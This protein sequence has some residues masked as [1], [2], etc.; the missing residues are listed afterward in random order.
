MILERLFRTRGGA[1]LVII[2]SHA[3]RVKKGALLKSICGTHL[4]PDRT[5]NP[6]LKSDDSG[7]PRE[8][9]Q[10]EAGSSCRGHT[11]SRVGTGELH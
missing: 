5:A 4:P 9:L 1:D 2:G 8:N 6:A 3:S 7:G 10:L 11:L